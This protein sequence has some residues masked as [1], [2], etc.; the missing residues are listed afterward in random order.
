MLYSQAQWLLFFFLYC[1]LG[2]VWEC[3]YVSA[4]TKHWVN[5][6]FLYGP[7]IPIYGFGAI[8]VL[9]ITLPVRE[10]IPLIFLFGMLG[11]TILEYFT[12]AAMERLFHVRYWDYSNN[13]LNLNGHICLFCSLGWGVFSVLMVKVFHLP[14]ENTILKIPASIANFTSMVLV[15]A[16]TVDTTKSV[17]TAIDL[18][19]LLKEFSE[20]SAVLSSLEDKFENVSENIV[21]NSQKF[22]NHILEIETELKNNRELLTQ[23]KDLLNQ[24]YRIALLNRLEE[25]RARKNRVLVLLNRKLDAYIEELE[26]MLKSDI[27]SKNHAWL[28]SHITE[29]N[30]FKKKLKH[31]DIMLK[32]YKDKEFQRAADIIRRNPSA[33][34]PK[35]KKSFH[36]LKALFDSRYKDGNP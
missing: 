27:P 14:F 11:A 25:H 17:Q 16:F 29:L 36:E 5:R 35:F 2:W 3:L 32:A 21:L 12:G 24:S 31:I 8:T 33:T 19:E 30:A 20:H 7:L 6:G 1:F 23:K 4:L 10:S 13:R 22:R 9:W 18:R 34:S 26:T 28:I 15:I